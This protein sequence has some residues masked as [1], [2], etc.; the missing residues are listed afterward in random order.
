MRFRGEDGVEDAA[1]GGEIFFARR[2]IQPDIRHF[3]QRRAEIPGIGAAKS[4]GIFIVKIS[5]PERGGVI[6]E[7]ALVVDAVADKQPLIN[8]AGIFE[9]FAPFRPALF[10][11]LASPG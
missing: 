11:R 5:A 2:A 6:A 9:K 3:A 8:G 10:K 7:S 1:P 4:E